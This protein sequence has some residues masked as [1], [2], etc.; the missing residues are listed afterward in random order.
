M[1]LLHLVVARHRRTRCEHAQLEV[2]AIPRTRLSAQLG[3]GVERPVDEERADVVATPAAAVAVVVVIVVET[4][5]TGSHETAKAA[6]KHFVHHDAK[7][8]RFGHT[9]VLLKVW[10]VDEVGLP[11]NL[12][13]LGLVWLVTDVVFN[14]HLA[15]TTPGGTALVQEEPSIAFFRL[16]QAL[17]RLV[18]PRK[19]TPATALDGELTD[20]TIL[21]VGDDVLR[22]V[23]GHVATAA[24]ASARS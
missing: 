14:R 10:A 7:L 11:Q 17:M 8:C 2:A 12:A 16:S 22:H 19:A 15:L 13:L 21:W 6:T 4:H 3:M 20:L 9:Q 1:V 23:R 18:I 24:A 5:A